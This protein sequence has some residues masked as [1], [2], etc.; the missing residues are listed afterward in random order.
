MFQGFRRRCG[1]YCDG[2]YFFIFYSNIRAVLRSSLAMLIVHW[3]LFARRASAFAALCALH[4]AKQNALTCV[5]IINTVVH[6]IE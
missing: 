3:V 1:M 5:V 6:V 4:F 2:A